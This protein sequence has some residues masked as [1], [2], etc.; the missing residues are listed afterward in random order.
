MK[1]KRTIHNKDYYPIPDLYTQLEDIMSNFDF[2]QVLEYMN[3]DKSRREYD[4][5]G[6]CIGT[7]TWKVFV[8]GSFKIPTLEELKQFAREQLIEVIKHYQKTKEYTFTSCGPFT[9]TCR[10]D[11]LELNCILERWSGD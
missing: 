11:V 10:N 4:E 1:T 8:N 3:W 2:E 5:D 6:R 7:H 9:S